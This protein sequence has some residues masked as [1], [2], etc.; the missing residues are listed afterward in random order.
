MSDRIIGF[1]ILGALVFF[2]LLVLILCAVLIP[3]ISHGT[4]DGIES[5][6]Q[7]YDIY[8]VQESSCVKVQ[9]RDKEHKENDKERQS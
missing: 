9:L 3:I 7:E 5:I 2:I 1:I 4:F 8:L 6:F